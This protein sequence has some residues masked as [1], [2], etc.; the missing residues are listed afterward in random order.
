M[1]RLRAGG[2]PS[3][4]AR[5]NDP[6]GRA[7]VGRAERNR[8]RSSAKVCGGEITAAGL[9][10]EALKADCLQVARDARAQAARAHRLVHRDTLQHLHVGGTGKW[11]TA[12]QHLIQDHAQGVDVRL[13]A[14]RSV[15]ALHLLRRHVAGRSQI[16]AAASLRRAAL[17]KLGQSEIGDL[18]NKVEPVVRAGGRD[19]VAAALRSE[20][21]IAWLQV[22]VDDSVFVRVIKRRGESG[23]QRGGRRHGDRFGSL[24]QPCRQRRPGAILLGN[25]IN[26]PPLA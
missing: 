17:E 15:S 22:P 23:H 6:S 1:P 12:R 14:D 16:Q 7:S 13:A 11:R 8:A 19:T 9:L 24:L 5:P 3:L 10:L 26:R 20:H 4:T 2:E 21:D 18:R 25:V